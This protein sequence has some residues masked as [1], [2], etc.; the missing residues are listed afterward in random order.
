M[1]SCRHRRRLIHL[2]NLI[3]SLKRQTKIIRIRIRVRVRIK[4]NLN[5]SSNNRNR[6]IKI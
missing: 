1:I 3:H 4:D 5:N 6:R 2:V